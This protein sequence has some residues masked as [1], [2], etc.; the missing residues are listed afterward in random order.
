[1]TFMPSTVHNDYDNS[2]IDALPPRSDST[3]HNDATTSDQ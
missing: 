3:I 1:M 2:T